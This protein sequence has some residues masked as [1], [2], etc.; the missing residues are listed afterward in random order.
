MVAPQLQ[1]RVLWSAL[2]AC[3]KKGVWVLELTL[4]ILSLVSLVTGLV[5]GFMAR[6]HRTP[7]SPPIPSFNPIH[8]VTPWKLPDYFTPLGIKYY[9]SSLVCL[10]LGGAIYVL[11]SGLPSLFG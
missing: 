9:I 7:L 6:K 2:L 3:S 1:L 4:L 8:W 11:V 10:L 5:L